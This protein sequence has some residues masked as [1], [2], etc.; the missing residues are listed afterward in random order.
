MEKSDFISKMLSND[1][2]FYITYKIS[3]PG[4]GMQQ[5]EIFKCYKCKCFI[6]SYNDMWPCIDTNNT[7]NK[8]RL[9]AHEDYLLEKLVIKKSD[10]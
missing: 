9:C 5:R 3:I 8:C 2:I 7:N 4:G 6:T 1:N 10:L